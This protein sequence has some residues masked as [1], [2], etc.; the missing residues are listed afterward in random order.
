MF[1]G[2]SNNNNNLH[3]SESMQ[4]KPV[5]SKFQ[6]FYGSSHSKPVSAMSVTDGIK[7]VILDFFSFLLTLP[8]IPSSKMFLWQVVLLGE[9]H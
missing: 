6:Q 9:A 4:F 2:N 5:F 3:V 7:E 8:L 1:P